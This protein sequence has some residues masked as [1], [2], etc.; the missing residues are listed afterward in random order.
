MTDTFLLRVAS[1]IKDRAQ[2][3]GDPRRTFEAIARR[4]SDIFGVQ[5]TPAQVALALADLKIARLCH[6][7]NNADGALDLAGYA[8]LLALLQD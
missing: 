4:W 7:P 6:D 5:V 1:T 2:T 8:T 3:H